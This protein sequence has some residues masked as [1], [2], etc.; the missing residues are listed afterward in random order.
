[1]DEPYDR[2]ADEKDKTQTELNY[3]EELNRYIAKSPGTWVEKFNNFPK[4]IS[5][6][7]LTYFLV[8]Y[9]LFRLI[10][11]VH[12]SIVECGVFM[13]G[14]LLGYAQ[15]SAILEPF[16]HQRR[17]VGFDTFDGFPS[18]DVKDGGSGTVNKQVGGLAADS[19][20]DIAEAARLFDANRPIG[21]IP[22]V[23]LV[24]GDACKSIPEYVSDNPHLIV[25]L[26]YL[27]MDVYEPTKIAL[28]QFVPR[29]PKGAIIAFDEINAKDWPGETTALFETVGISNLR[30]ERFSFDSHAAYAI[31][32]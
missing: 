22:K 6:Q 5:R 25:S 1:M 20:D 14:N 21:H 28:E 4:Y 11:N 18:L 30:L 7:Y 23:E 32:D 10:T 8:R 19:M 3:Y 13:G 31:I 29:M 27:D 24:K 12:G 15:M 26:L 2:Q 16:N 17:I 9:E